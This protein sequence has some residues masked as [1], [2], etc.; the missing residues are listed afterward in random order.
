MDRRNTGLVLRYYFIKYPTKST[1]HVSYYS[2]HTTAKFLPDRRSWLII[3]EKHT[4]LMCAVGDIEQCKAM[5]VVHESPKPLRVLADALNDDYIPLVR[6][7]LSGRH[8][9]HEACIDLQQCIS[10]MQGIE[11]NRVLRLASTLVSL[12]DV[13]SLCIHVCPIA[14]LR[15]IQVECVYTMTPHMIQ[16]RCGLQ[17]SDRVLFTCLE[18]HGMTGLLVTND[19]AVLFAPTEDGYL[20]RKWLPLIHT[21]PDSILYVESARLYQTLPE[22]DVKG[23]LVCVE[24]ELGVVTLT[25]YQRLAQAVASVQA[26]IERYLV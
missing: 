25:D 15:V 24:D 13:N 2:S 14:G 16:S 1:R 19:T 9:D 11:T 4:I 8:L 7:L 17:S 3:E 22:L 26:S 18:T 21:T 5:P 10:T 20:Y 23:L 6:L 12:P